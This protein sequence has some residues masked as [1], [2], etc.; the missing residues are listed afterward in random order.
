MGFTR[1]DEEQ[2][3]WLGFNFYTHAGWDPSRFG[4]FFQDMIDAGYDKT[5]A[6][7]SDHPTLAS[8]V[9]N[10]QK[11]VKELPP[12]AASWRRP[13][14]ADEQ[15]FAQLKARAAELAKKLP[16]DA[17]LQNSQ[18][19]LQALPRSCIIPYTTQDE[20]QARQALQQKAQQRQQA[21]A[22]GPQASAAAPAPKKKKKH[23]AQATGNEVI[24]SPTPQ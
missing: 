12:Q 23:P 11:W 5:P 14:V 3:D 13:P 17:S 1:G 16:D 7:M 20:L 19:L 9:Q 6:I 21:G 10:V 18:Q 15:R 2:A 22:G 4:E 24:S 8:R